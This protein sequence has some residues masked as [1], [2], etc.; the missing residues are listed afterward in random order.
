MVTVNRIVFCEGW[1]PL[2]WYLMSMLYLD[3]TS[4]S[5]GCCYY[6]LSTVCFVNQV[7]NIKD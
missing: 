2:G 7:M 4:L 1:S 6:I 5:L 3:E